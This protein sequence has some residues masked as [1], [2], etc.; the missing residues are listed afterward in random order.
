[1]KLI[2]SPPM[3]QEKQ[4]AG[5]AHGRSLLPIAASALLL[6]CAHGSVNPIG[7]GVQPGQKRSP[8]NRREPLREKAAGAAAYICSFS[9]G[10]LTYLDG[11]REAS[12][13]LDVRDANPTN[14]LCSD[15]YTVLLE[16]DRA[17]VALGGR[18]VLE[19]REM[20]GML[21]GRPVAANSYTVDITEV[22]EEGISEVTLLGSE[23]LITTRRSRW[24]LDLRDPVEWHIY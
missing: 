1:M 20:L 12:I 22:R 11:K 16:G 23:L 24:R 14:I 15:I 19:G 5:P 8:F 9:D 4:G 17:V 6:S 18:A 13:R 2:R 10:S 3:H 21:S 7:P